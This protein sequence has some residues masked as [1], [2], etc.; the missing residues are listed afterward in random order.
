[1]SSYDHFS[2]SFFLSYFWP[3]ILSMCFYPSCIQL[4]HHSDKIRVFR[5]MRLEGRLILLEFRIECTICDMSADIVE[6]YIDHIQIPR[7]S[8]TTVCC[9]IVAIS[10]PSTRTIKERRRS[11]CGFSEFGADPSDNSIFATRIPNILHALRCICERSLSLQTICSNIENAHAL[12]CPDHCTPSKE[13]HE[14]TIMPDSEEIEYEVYCRWCNPYTHTT[15]QISREFL[16]ISDIF[17]PIFFGIFHSRRLFEDL[18]GTSSMNILLGGNSLCLDEY[19]LSFCRILEKVDNNCL[20]WL[21]ESR[22]AYFCD[23]GIF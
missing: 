14:E 11:S 3:V 17:I 4:I 9:N 13:L 15:D 7:G 22:I 5:S 19:R 18:L 23:I 8:I 21:R 20:I 6:W 1:M 10:E 12:Q 16:R 2:K